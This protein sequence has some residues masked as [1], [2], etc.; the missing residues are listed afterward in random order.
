MSISTTMMA[1]PVERLYREFIAASDAAA[2]SGN[3]DRA[4]ILDLE[5]QIAPSLPGSAARSW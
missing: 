2:R 5:A 4:R 1:H 3:E